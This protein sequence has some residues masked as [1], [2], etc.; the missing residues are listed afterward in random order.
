VAGRPAVLPQRER[1][2]H[3]YSRVDSVCSTA[4]ASRWSVQSWRGS[5]PRLPR[6]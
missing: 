5:T 2:Q 6:S 4:M 3:A 1:R